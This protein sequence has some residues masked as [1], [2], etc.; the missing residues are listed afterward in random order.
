MNKILFIITLLISKLLLANSYTK[1]IDSLIKS[2]NINFKDTTLLNKL[3]LI[4]EAYENISLDSA[5]R[6]YELC[7]NVAEELFANE[8]NEKL[9]YHIYTINAKALKNIG[10]IYTYKAE[11]DKA[12]EYYF[13]SVRKFSI[14]RNI[15]GQAELFR[16]IGIIY[17][18]KGDYDLALKHYKYSMNFAIA[19]LDTVQ[20]ANAYSNIGI[21]YHIKGNYK[22]AMEFYIKQLKLIE[23]KNDLKSLSA[24]YIN[25]GNLYKDQFQY[26]EALNYYNKALSLKNKLKDNLGIANIYNNIGLIYFNKNDYEKSINH[27]FKALTFY[28]EANNLQGKSTTYTNVGRVYYSLNN[29]SKAIEFFEKAYDIDKQIGFSEGKLF[30]LSG[31]GFSY[32]HLSDSI[33]NNVK[34][35]YLQKALKIGLELEKLADQKKSVKHLN[36]AYNI[37][38]L[39]YKR[40]SDFKNAVFYSEKLL[41]NIYKSFSEDF[42]KGV[43]EL[44]AKY[45]NEKKEIL[46][47]KLKKENFYKQ[48]LLEKNLIIQKKQRNFI[49]VIVIFLVISITAIILIFRS[50]IKLNKYNKLIQQQK[51]DIE[52]K[53]EKLEN[54]YNEIQ[55]QKEEIC[56]QRDI[57]TKQNILLAE[58]NKDINDSIKYASYIQKITLPEIKNIKPYFDTFLIFKPK[59]QLSGDF[60]WY[61]NSK[62][63]YIF[64]VADSTGHGIPGSLMSMI[65]I[66]LLNETIKNKNIFSPKLIIENLRNNALEILSHSFRN[67]DYKGGID[68]SVVTFNTTTNNLYYSGANSSM[69]I[70]NS[71][72]KANVIKGDK[73]TIGYNYKLTPINE[74]NISYK[75]NDV[76]YLYTDGIKDQIGGPNGKKFLLKNFIKLLE[77][78]YFLDVNQQKVLIEN[79]IDEWQNANNIHYNQTDDITILGIKVL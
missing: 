10:I 49:I 18:Y 6:Y 55:Q 26:D 20:L 32:V 71:N 21:I 8:K 24:C 75:P 11:Y 12:L 57:V 48:S 60:Y 15:R 79:K 38:Y 1:T 77:N 42:A 3:I 52:A 64:V 29:Y 28:E 72:G 19:S 46:I 37:L 68:M 62:E 45:E 70:I 66:S 36:D 47:S 56:L 44:Q 53:N 74:Y 9:K 50:N 43:A 65:G 4:G 61:F 73:T 7:H 40:L 58:L 35:K 22:K 14:I 33:N 63:L 78:I 2:V 31:L 23:N 41:N 39:T 67:T 34:F 69:I 30:Y 17:Y 16:Y 76:I 5:I 59:E 25:I 13:H 51:A 27:F 54:A